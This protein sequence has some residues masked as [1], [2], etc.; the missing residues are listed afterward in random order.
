[1]LPGTLHAAQDPEHAP[2]QQTPSTQKPDK[3]FVASVHD[4]PRSSLQTPDPSQT[5]PVP[6]FVP[7]AA[8]ETPHNPSVHVLVLQASSMPGQSPG[9]MQTALP[10]FPPVFPLELEEEPPMPPRLGT[11]STSST[12]TMRLHAEMPIIAAR[13]NPI[14]RSIMA[15][16]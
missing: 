13:P 2:S 1:M 15:F 3:Q 16:T 14:R 7:A 4:V 9:V 5:R 8:L 12:P 10:P 11:T 6:Q